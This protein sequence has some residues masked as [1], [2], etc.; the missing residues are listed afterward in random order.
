M[1]YQWRQSLARFFPQARQSRKARFPGI[2]NQSLRHALGTRCDVLERRLR[3][4]RPAAYCM[5]EHCA[6]IQLVICP[7]SYD[8][9]ARTRPLPHASLDDL[10]AVVKSWRARGAAG[11]GLFASRGQLVWPRRGVLW[12]G[13]AARKVHRLFCGYLRIST[14]LRRQPG[15]RARCVR[16]PAGS[17]PAASAKPTVRRQ[18]AQWRSTTPRL[19]GTQNRAAAHDPS[20]AALCRDRSEQASQPTM[21]LAH[22]TGAWKYECTASCAQ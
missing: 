1:F 8:N 19:G 16:G 9:R 3:M 15:S 18:G 11:S 4:S 14:A 12:F 2:M 17:T 6:K 21:R 13:T 22:D 7:P 10:F 5:D 20:G